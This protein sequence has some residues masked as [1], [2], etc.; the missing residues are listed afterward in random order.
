[1][2]RYTYLL[3]ENGDVVDPEVARSDLRKT[4]KAPVVIEQ[5]RKKKLFT[6]KPK[7]APTPR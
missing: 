4:K 7:T 3:D 6:P 2:T 5:K 1:V